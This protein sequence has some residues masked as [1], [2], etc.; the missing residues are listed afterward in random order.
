MFTISEDIN[1]TRYDGTIY[2]LSDFVNEM[3]Q[4]WQQ[5][6]V[7]EHT[8]VDITQPEAFNLLYIQCLMA[9]DNLSVLNDLRVGM[10]INT[11][12][13]LFLDDVGA[14]VGVYRQEGTF[15]TGQVTFTLG[16]PLSSQLLIPGGTMVSTDD[17]IIFATNSDATINPGSLTTTVNVTCLDLGDIGNVSPGTIVNINDALGTDN[18]TVTNTSAT[19][20]GQQEESDDDYRARI[21]D[22]HLNYPVGTAKW[23]ETIAETIVLQAKFISTTAGEGTIIYHAEDGFNVQDLIN[24]FQEPQYNDPAVALTFTAGVADNVLNGVTIHLTLGTGIEPSV[25]ENEINELL[26][27]YCNGIEIGGEFVAERVKQYVESV[28]G[29]VSASYDGL[30]DV[31]LANNAYANFT[32]PTYD[33]LG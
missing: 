21:M 6:V 30:N 16:A 24:L 17:T 32:A 15:A 10:N 5:Q 26:T 20:G 33:V 8:K 7:E 22:S 28:N 2:Y 18:I 13:N 31:A 9:F 3:L 1:F 14:R 19:S 27:D 29:V 23:F 11:A 12:E 4:D 25:V